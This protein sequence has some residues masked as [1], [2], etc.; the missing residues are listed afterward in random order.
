MEQ[1]SLFDLQAPP[2]AT[3]ARTYKAGDLACSN[4]GAAWPGMGS[5]FWQ[6]D[7]AGRWYHWCSGGRPGRWAPAGEVG[8]HAEN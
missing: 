6:R 7:G 5:G 3:S 1:L 8:S 4:C 2:A